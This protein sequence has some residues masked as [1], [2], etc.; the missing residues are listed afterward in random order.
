M[1]VTVMRDTIECAKKRK[2]I[3][4]PSLP[5]QWMTSVRCAKLHKKIYLVYEMS[6][7]D[8]FNF[9]PM[10]ETKDLKWKKSTDNDIIKWNKIKEIST[11]FER[12]FTIHFKYMITLIQIF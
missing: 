3:Y 8:I 9:K 11:S 5:S 12:P 7:E 4:V 2:V 6:N 10:V 1:K